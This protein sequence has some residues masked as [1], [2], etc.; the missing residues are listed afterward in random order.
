MELLGNAA[1]LGGVVIVTRIIW[2][3]PGAILPRK[4]IPS[5]RAHDPMPPIRNIAVVAWCGM[6]GVV[7][8][9][10]ALAIPHVLSNGKPFPERDLVLFFTFCIILMTLVGQGLSLPWVIR[11]L[12]VQTGHRDEQQE[13]EARKAAAHAALARIEKFATEERFTPEA[14]NAVEALYQ[15]RLYHLGDELAEALGW[16]PMRQRSVE[17]RR[18]RRAAVEA[19]RKQLIAMHREHKL[20]KDLLHKLER[21]LDLEE[22]RLS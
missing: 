1:L 5:I 7:S 17:S 15:E 6:R 21:E 14:I 18:L 10:A 19:E 3:F 13:R 2:V 8:L 4:L 11:K 22:A 20:S 9:A 16:S 12:H